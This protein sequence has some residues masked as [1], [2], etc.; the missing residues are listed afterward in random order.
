MGDE[1]G[2][3]KEGFLADI[4]ATKEHPEKNVLALQNVSFVMKEGKH[5]K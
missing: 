2:Q 1:L 5:I 4:V 3:I